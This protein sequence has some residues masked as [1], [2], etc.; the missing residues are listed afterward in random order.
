MLPYQQKVGNVLYI[1]AHVRGQLDGI[2]GIQGALVVLGGQVMCVLFGA[3]AAHDIQHRGDLLLADEPTG[4]LDRETGTAIMD[5]LK[6]LNEDEGR[7]IVMVTHDLSLAARA[8]RIVS[9]AG[10]RIVSDRAGQPA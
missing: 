2:E 9:L 5:L 6:R 10:G 7:T 1:L 8:H 3:D 4:D